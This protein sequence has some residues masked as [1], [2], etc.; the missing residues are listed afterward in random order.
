[1]TEG[2]F[3]VL[4]AARGKNP[5]IRYDDGSQVCQLLA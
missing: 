3:A 1:M 4:M 5:K 2:L